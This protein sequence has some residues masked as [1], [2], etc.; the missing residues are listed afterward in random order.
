MAAQI[1][2]AENL[3]KA[4]NLGKPNEVTPVDGISLSIPQ[5][6]CVILKGPSGSG[7]TTLLTLLSCLARPTAGTYHCLG[8]Q[9]SRWSE[10]FLTRF[11]QQHIGVVFQQFNLIGGFTAGVNISLPLMPSGISSVKLKQ[12]VEQAANW[13]Q[14]EHRLSFPIQQLSG[15]ELQRVAIA[16]ALI[17]QPEILFADEPTSHLD[18]QMAANTL[19]V[20][21]GL[22]KKGKTL[23]MTT[24]DPMVEAHP[25]VDLV[26][27]VKDGKLAVV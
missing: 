17:N 25:M 24:H 3:K 2:V 23:V 14:I 8:E 18:T 12:R 7:K 22:K 15:G 9:V 5:G 4:F 27:Q 10:K 20:F 19:N 11:R 16:R 6:A 1:M 21:D 13:V 26:F